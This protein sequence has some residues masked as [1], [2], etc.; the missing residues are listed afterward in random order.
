MVIM[1]IVN[2]DQ[3]ILFSNFLNSKLIY[4]EANYVR[5]RIVIGNTS[6]FIPQKF[7]GDD[8]T[9][10][11]TVYVRGSKEE[12][13]ISSFVKKAR[14][15]IDPSFAPNDVIDVHHPPFHL[16]RRGYGEFQVIIQLHFKGNTDINKPLEIVHNLRLDKAKTGKIVNATET[17]ADIELDK[18]ALAE[19]DTFTE[20]QEK[21]VKQRLTIN[22][23]D[24]FADDEVVH[25]KAKTK[26][27]SKKKK[28]ST[29][30]EAV[31]EN[32]VSSNSRF[33][34]IYLCRTRSI[35]K[36]Y[37]LIISL[38]QIHPFLQL[39]L[40]LMYSVSFRHHQ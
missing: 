34:L 32:S 6:Q 24:E 8:Y 16:S 35:M 13:D 25:V 40:I 9:H 28:R 37:H 22:S 1:M 20:A 5:K 2:T 14:I 17:I 27:P 36:Y 4:K 26:P 31:D 23:D 30:A 10:K 7:R 15:T 29:G 21:K 12:P 19:T 39:V 38:Y 3:M 18:Q 11:W 33:I